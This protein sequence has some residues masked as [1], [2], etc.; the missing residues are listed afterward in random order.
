MSSEIISYDEIDQ[1]IELN[2]K[3]VTHGN[4]PFGVNKNTI[5]DIINSVNTGRFFSILNE[6]ERI[7]R[8]ASIILARI[9]WEQP[10]KEG[11]RRTALYFTI[12]YLNKNKLDLLVGNYKIKNLIFNLQKRTIEKFETDE[13][14]TED[15]FQFLNQNVIDFKFTDF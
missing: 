11:N 15:I 10:F 12:Q 7:I 8:R 3:I 6:R 14:I 5:Y 13:S 9:T 2:R 1:I 4:E